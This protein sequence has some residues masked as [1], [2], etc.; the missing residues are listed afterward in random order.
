MHDA[1]A[2]RP[3]YA[4]LSGLL[5][6]CVFQEGELGPSVFHCNPGLIRQVV[7]CV[8]I[9][10]DGKADKVSALHQPVKHDLLAPARPVCDWH[11]QDKCD[12]DYYRIQSK[13]YC[14]NSLEI[15]HYLTP[16]ALSDG[17]P[18]LRFCGM[19]L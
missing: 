15:R 5:E 18:D 13:Q 11:Q 17:I 6:P 14:G 10:V 4:S 2:F 12:K 19:H 9:T 8:G 16:P 1:S 7:I 3:V